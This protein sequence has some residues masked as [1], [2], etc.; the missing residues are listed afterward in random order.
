[1]SGPIDQI[2]QVNVKVGSIIPSQIAFGIPM[3]A[4]QF[5]TSRSAREFP[6]TRGTC[7]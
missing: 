7:S 2:V 1:M 6:G 4:A 3:I 5:A